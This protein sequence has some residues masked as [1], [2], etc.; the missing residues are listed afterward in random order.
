MTHLS[1]V[2]LNIVPFVVVFQSRAGSRRRI[3]EGSIKCLSQT[4]S[5]HVLN[6]RFHNQPKTIFRIFRFWVTIE[7]YVTVVAILLRESN[8]MQFSVRGDKWYSQDLRESRPQ[9]LPF[10]GSASD[11]NVI[12]RYI[13]FLHFW[14][15]AMLFYV[16]L[17]V[18]C[19]YCSIYLN[20]LPINLSIYYKSTYPSNNLTL[21]LSGRKVSFRALMASLKYAPSVLQ[22]S[23]PVLT[24]SS[25]FLATDAADWAQKTYV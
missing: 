7:I 16:L 10:P 19:I 6:I 11:F 5:T 4:H 22:V 9:Y 3:W 21:P 24:H 14:K 18:S 12:P 2:S 20:H 8:P 13:Y 25:P 17:C 23:T 1:E 15:T